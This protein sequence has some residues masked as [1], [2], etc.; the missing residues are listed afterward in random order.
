M[1]QAMK[2]IAIA[3]ALALPIMT[4]PLMTMSATASAQMWSGRGS[5]WGSPGWNRGYPSA[6]V[7]DSG[8]RL[9]KIEVSRFTAQG[10]AAAE[11]MKGAIAAVRAPNATDS[12]AGELE[13]GVYQAASIDQLAKFG[14]QTAI[15]PES[16]NQIA[17]VR[18]SHGVVVPQEEP[19][20]P[21]SGMM[22]AG[23]SNR[24]SGLALG[25]NVDL[26]R[27]RPAVLS[28]KLEVRIR[29]RATHMALWE[30]RAEVVTRAGDPKWND[31]ATAAKLAAALFK[32]FPGRSNEAFTAK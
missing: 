29:D 10:P 23:V 22:E 14:Y 16:A 2:R 1:S 25:I 3:V 18:I 6:P 12:D 20:K 32:G 24:G 8:L 26:S 19:H 7:S 15:P 9:G 17:E 11:L 30:G 27:P 4:V 5:G 21:V 31:N 13:L 28:T